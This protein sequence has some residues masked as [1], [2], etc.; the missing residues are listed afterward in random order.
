MRRLLEPGYRLLSGAIAGGLTYILSVSL[1]QGTRM[2]LAWNIGVIVVIGLIAIMMQRSDGQ[3]CCRRARKEETSSAV[4]LTVTIV[5]VIGALTFIAYGLANAN[6]LSLALRVM[7]LGLSI[8]GVLLA[9][10]MTHMIY[11]LHYAKLY[12]SDIDHGGAERLGTPLVFPGD[13]D[14]VDY[15][16]FVY[17]SLTIAMCFQTSDVTITSPHM[18]RLTIFHATF[19]YFFAL[20]ILGLMLDLISNII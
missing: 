20:V 11:S 13:K 5:A 10:L 15:W 9:W 3:E 18:R 17:F 16:D 7:H 2:V 6:R 19:S 4:I 14:V 1:P 8:A 12:Y